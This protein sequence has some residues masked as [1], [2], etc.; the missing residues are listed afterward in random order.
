MSSDQA[1]GMGRRDFCLGAASVLAAAIPSGQAEAA[2]LE[3]Y[4]VLVFSN[5]TSA[6]LEAEYN[7]WYEQQHIPDLLKVR[8]FHDAHRYR[9]VKTLS[10]GSTL[11]PYLAIYDVRTDDMSRATAQVMQRR[12][13]GQIRSSAAFDYEHSV[14]LIY[15]PR[16]P[17]LLAAH[18]LGTSP[19]PTVSGKAPVNYVLAVFSNPMAGREDEYNAWYDTQHLPDVLRNPGFVSGRRYVLHNSELPGYVPPRYL[20]LFEFQSADLEHT[21]AEVVRRLDSGQ[22]RGSSSIDQNGLQG[23]YMKALTP[24]PG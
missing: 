23:Y 4:A 22:T 14:T 12:K 8:G 24:A 19:A 17:V 2:R 15:Q 21:A 16:A 3:D 6:E 5:P 18:V 7:R 9:T 11:P 20:A 1:T 10:A 13:S